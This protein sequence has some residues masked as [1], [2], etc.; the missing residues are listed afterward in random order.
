MF[1]RE[2]F[3]DG[4]DRM[5]K[6]TKREKGEKMESHEA[7][8]SVDLRSIP[9]AQRNCAARPS[10]NC[11]SMARWWSE[12]SG[13]PFHVRELV[14]LAGDGDTRRLPIERA[15][16]ELLEL[17]AE[18][19][20]SGVRSPPGSGKTLVLPQVLLE[21]KPNDGRSPSVVVALPTQYAAQKIKESLVEHRRWS[22][23]EVRLV[24]GQTRTTSTRWRPR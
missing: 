15:Y 22:P 8:D 13:T 5:N 4:Q 18:H 2:C 19:K 17:T 23:E 24:T 14:T 16:R 9:W 3:E 11:C 7:T 12:A 21:W 1:V 10:V 6:R 20:V